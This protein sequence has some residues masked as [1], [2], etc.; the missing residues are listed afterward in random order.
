MREAQGYPLSLAVQLEPER[1][2]ESETNEQTEKESDLLANQASDVTWVKVWITNSFA[3]LFCNGLTVT[4]DP[5]SIL[6]N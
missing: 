4:S 2:A 5:S 3:Y 1:S 6:G